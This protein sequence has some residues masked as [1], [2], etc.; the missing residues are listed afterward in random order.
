MGRRRMHILRNLLFVALFMATLISSPGTGHAALS[1]DYTLGAGGA[2]SIYYNNNASLN[3]VNIPVTNI[4]GYN[5]SLNSGT[6]L[7]ITG[8]MLNFQTGA[9]TSQS[10][11]SW[12]FGA[13]GTITVVGSAPG[14]TGTT[15]LTGTFSSAS[16]TES[17]LGFFQLDIANATFNGL[18]NASIYQY[19][20]GSSSYVSSSGLVVSFIGTNSATG[21]ASQSNLGGIFSGVIADAP[22]PTPTP[23]PAAAWLLGTGLIGLVGIRR[24]VKN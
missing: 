13:G 1:I 7:A 23:V 2:G 15:L 3:G 16:V 19:F 22:T 17:P 12:T 6:S 8:G 20:L 11:N 21:F 18:E 24:K 9:L 10:G 4:T 14:I 5:T